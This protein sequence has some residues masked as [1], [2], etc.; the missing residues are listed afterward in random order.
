MGKQTFYYDNPISLFIKACGYYR[1][2]HKMEQC[3]LEELR[4]YQ[5]ARVRDTIGYAITH[6]PWYREHYKKCGFELGDL[7]SLEDLKGLPFITKTTIQESAPGEFLSDET[8]KLRCAYLHTSGTT[9]TPMEFACDIEDRASKYAITMLGFQ[10][11]G[12]R[13]RTPEFVLKELFYSDAP[14]YYNRWSN[15]VLMHASRNSKENCLACEKLLRKHP[16]RHVWAHPNALLEFGTSIEDARKTFSELRGITVMSEPLVPLLREKLEA[17]FGA[18]VFDFYSNKESTL[19]AYETQRQGY[20]LCEHF[21]YNEILST[22]GSDDPMTGEIISTTFFK[23]AMPF[24]RYKSA[25]EVKLAPN[26]H[27]GAFRE[28]VEVSGRISDAFLLPDGNHVRVWNLH[29]CDF[30]NI[31]SY[32]FIQV[33]KEHICIDV[34]PQNASLPINDE[35]L[36]KELESYIGKELLISVRQ[37]EQLHKTKAGKIPRL[38]SDVGK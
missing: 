17:C 14:F 3:G 26:S 34:V 12:Y 23:R 21:S 9:G 18:K 19:I 4:E 16:V 1:R 11:S 30:T 28:V 24:I 5:L 29:H 20:M 31:Q 10:E 22:D 7:K 13:L 2:F 8:D 27:G 35:S 37:V 25:D 15:R 33:D 36:I 32:Q 6:I 38:I